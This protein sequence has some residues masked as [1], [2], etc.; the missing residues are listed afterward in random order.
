MAM[1]DF[2]TRL[3]LLEKMKEKYPKA[4]T[5]ELDIAI[6]GFEE[7]IELV[8]LYRE[9]PMFSK[10]VDDVWHFFILNTK[11]YAAWC[12]EELGFFLHHNPTDKNAPVDSEE[13]R[14]ALGLLWMRACKE[15]RLDPFAFPPRRET[16]N[17]FLADTNLVENF[18]DPYDTARQV[19]EDKEEAERKAAS[20]GRFFRPKDKTSYGEA[21][22][23]DYPVRSTSDNYSSAIDAIVI[24]SVVD[25]YPT[26][27]KS[28]SSHNSS[29]S[30]NDDSSSHHSNHSTTTHHSCGSS[31]HSS[32]SCSSSS[33]SCSSSSCGSSSSCSS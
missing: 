28:E 13:E 17:L 12:D 18:I 2:K 1:I 16:P 19:K 14:K 3:Y 8:K 25:S 6:R 32:H 26:P 7:Y 9:V 5:E 22:R 24:S 21:L 29:S 15:Q 33:H 20:L 11:A 10:S 23:K 27:V 31:S 4:D 30:R